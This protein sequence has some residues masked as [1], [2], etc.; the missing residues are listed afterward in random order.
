MPIVIEKITAKGLGPL[1]EFSGILGRFNLFYGRNEQGK[2]FLVEFILKSLFKNINMF[3]LR[4]ITSSGQVL[5]SGLVPGLSQFSPTS[6][7]KIEHYWEDSVQ[8]MPSNIAQLL[9]V[10][11]AELDFIDTAPGGISKKI[12]KSFLSSEGILDKI[13]DKVQVTVQEARIEN[14]EIIGVNRGDLKNRENILAQLSQIEE[15]ID[16]VNQDYSGG[17]LTSLLSQKKELLDRQ[18]DQEKAKRFFAYHLA[19]TIQAYH[20]K[21]LSMVER[22]LPKLIE[23]HE[24]LKQ[25]LNDRQKLKE[26][27][28]EAKEKSKEYDWINSA[29][30]EYEKFLNRGGQIPQRTNLY[31]AATLILGAASL[32]LIGF[33]FNQLE[34]GDYGPIIYCGIGIVAFLGLLFGF[35]YFQ[36]QQKGIQNIA[37]RLELKRI[38]NAYKDIFDKKL[39]DIVTL[40]NH[41]Q[42]IQEAYHK[43]KS[44][45]ENVDELEST[46]SS[47][48][49][50]ISRGLDRFDLKTE[51]ESFWEESIRQLD[52]INK[53]NQEFIRK[54]EIEL[55]NL[56]V[57]PDQYLKSNLGIR[58]QKDELTKLTNEMADLQRMIQEEENKLE[59]LKV[60]IRTAISDQT[61]TSWEKLLG[62]LGKRKIQLVDSYKDITSKICAG[63]LV[64]QVINDVRHQEDEKLRESLCMP[65][66]QKP[67][68]EITKRYKEVTLDGENLLVSDGYDEFDIAELSTATR[69]QVL[70]A[71]RLGFAAK[72]MNDETAFLILDD[73]FQHSDWLRRTFLMDTV[74][75]LALNGWQILYFTMDDHIRGLFDEIGR[76]SFKTDY[77]YFELNV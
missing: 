27:L 65:I 67:I 51:G 49:E 17:K 13:Q 50:H 46:I 29:L 69:E 40:K 15:I 5:V 63:I 28:E 38:E 10:K 2:T 30:I 45:A 14:G 61:T 77:Q 68:Y 19:N 35:L 6:R 44:L 57:E 39:T 9:V 48:K 26:R 70:L 58:Y 33:L 56:D 59:L 52:H 60:K 42:H 64:S 54:K 55:A 32:A 72:I 22:G 1:D 76:E 34:L 53:S 41:H 21:N 66:V 20:E 43:T 4:E 7:R 23:Q 24:T 74:A 3:N 37:Q 12:V 47:I 62:K 18:K 75:S 36:Q 73:A 11:G 8:G 25:K 31:L 71:L 16:E